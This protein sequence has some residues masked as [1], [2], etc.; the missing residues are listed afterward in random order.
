VPNN[1]GLHYLDRHGLP[2]YSAVMTLWAGEFYPKTA[3]VP[4][5]ANDRD[6][7]RIV[8]V[9]SHENVLTVVIGIC[10]NN[11]GRCVRKNHLPKRPFGISGKMAT[12]IRA[13]KGAELILFARS[14]SH[15]AKYHEQQ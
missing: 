5:I 12:P 13:G 8:C 10:F 15:G 11:G 2:S 7:R 6:S 3:E 9:R 4:N 14:E 1:I